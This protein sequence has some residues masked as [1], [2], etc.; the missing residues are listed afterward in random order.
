MTGDVE[1]AHLD[2]AELAS[3]RTFAASVATSTC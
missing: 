2:L 1:V 3:V